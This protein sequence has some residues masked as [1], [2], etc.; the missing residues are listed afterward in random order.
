M[1]F[2]Y[3]RKKNL[4][5]DLPNDIQAGVDA[6]VDSDSDSSGSGIYEA[7]SGDHLFQ[8]GESDSADLDGPPTLPPGQKHNQKKKKKKENKGSKN[9]YAKFKQF[10]KGKE[11][12]SSDNTEGA[13]KAVAG[14]GL[15][16]APQPV[17]V[18]DKLKRNLRKT[19]SS[20]SSLVSWEVGGLS[21]EDIPVCDSDGTD[22][23]ID[24]EMEQSSKSQSLDRLVE[25]VLKY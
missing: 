7:V 15:V 13:L 22:T 16:V 19:K 20:D 2:I 3:F 18:F 1:Y 5:E 11:G 4:A 12:K 6:D 17:G 10:Y 9:I 25:V 24:L 14:P 21:R 8:I 23:D